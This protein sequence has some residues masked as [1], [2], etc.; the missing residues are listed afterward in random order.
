MPDVDRDALAS[1]YLG[2]LLDRHK[3]GSSG[4][5]I[6]SAMTADKSLTFA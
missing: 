3:I 6:R 2:K 4:N 1:E 5:D